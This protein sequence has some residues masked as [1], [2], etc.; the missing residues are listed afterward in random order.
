MEQPAGFSLLA[1][2]AQHEAETPRKPRVAVPAAPPPAE[3]AAGEESEDEDDSAAWVPRLTMV[4][5]VE[6]AQLPP[7][8]GRLIALGLLKFELF[9]RTGGMRYRLSSTGRQVLAS[10]PPPAIE[11]ETVT[12][13]AEIAA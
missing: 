5:G 9:G 11:A 13:A 1:A 6:P 7:L 4:P 8:H 2:Y 10:A 3:S 12:E